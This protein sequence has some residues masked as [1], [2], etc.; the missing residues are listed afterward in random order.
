MNFIPDNE[1]SPYPKWVNAVSSLLLPGSGH[2]LSAKKRVGVLW[3]CAVQILYVG[4]FLAI[5]TT[6]VTSAVGIAALLLGALVIRIFMIVDSCKKPIPRVKP[7]IW[8]AFCLLVILIPM[9]RIRVTR[10]WFYRVFSIPTAAMQPTLMGN[11][12]SADG[13]IIKGDHIIVDEFIYHLRL[14]AR[15]DIAVFSTEAIDESERLRFGIPLRENY[16]KRVVGLPG[17]RV[18]VHS[19]EIYINGQKLTDPKIVDHISVNTNVAPDL[20]SRMLPDK[21]V[22][23]GADEYF[24]VGDNILNSLDSRY[25]GAIN[26]KFLLG[27]VT[28]IFWPLERYGAVQ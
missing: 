5:V 4:A 27:R 23:L 8:V 26:R 16:V 6:L 25:F 19:A 28:W 20:S 14:P 11:R 3:F 17:E 21:E 2:F 10:Q 13:Q 24:V 9:A 1:K 7:G 22:Q 18:S 15:G 12:K